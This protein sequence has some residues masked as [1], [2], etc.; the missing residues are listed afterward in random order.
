MFSINTHYKDDTSQFICLFATLGNEHSTSADCT[1]AW[2]TASPQRFADADTLRSGNVKVIHAF[3]FFPHFT[4]CHCHIHCMYLHL[5]VLKE[6]S[7]PVLFA[8]A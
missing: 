6:Q 7:L 5:Y 8:M 2:H 1:R 4:Q 3:S